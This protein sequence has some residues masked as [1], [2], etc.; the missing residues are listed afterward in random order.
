M[1]RSALHAGEETLSSRVSARLDDASKERIAALVAVDDAD[2]TIA[3][4]CDLENESGD[5]GERLVLDKLKETA[6]SVSLETMLTEIDKLLAVRAIGVSPGVFGD[7]V[8]SIVAGWRPEIPQQLGA[9][10][11]D[12]GA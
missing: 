11:G 8:P 1:M 5:R 3:P 2:E 4:D 12:R 10:A 7:I 6:G 9:P